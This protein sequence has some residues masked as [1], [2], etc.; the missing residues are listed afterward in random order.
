MPSFGGYIIP[1]TY[2]QNRSNNPLTRYLYLD[3]GKISELV[4]SMK[5][6]QRIFISTS[7]PLALVL[8]CSLLRAPPLE[9]FK[10]K[11]ESELAPWGTSNQCAILKKTSF[12]EVDYGNINLLQAGVVSEVIC[13]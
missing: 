7:K 10:Q 12:M 9:T 4:L 1:T 11:I 13:L 2:P 6:F 3:S 8:V 5:T